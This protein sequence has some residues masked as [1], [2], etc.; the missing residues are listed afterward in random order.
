MHVDHEATASEV[1]GE[2][3]EVEVRIEAFDPG[4]GVAD[5]GIFAGVA[6]LQEVKDCEGG[7][8]LEVDGGRNTSAGRREAAGGVKVAG[9]DGTVDVVNAGRSGDFEVGVGRVIKLTGGR[10]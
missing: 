2:Y 4:I 9:E 8:G 6:V 3:V 5:G 1:M 7:I 10:G